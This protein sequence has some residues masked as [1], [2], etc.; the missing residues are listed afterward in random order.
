M[1]REVRDELDATSIKPR[2]GRAL[3][4]LFLLHNVR[5]IERDL[6]DLAIKQIPFAT[7]LAINETLEDVQKNETK[8][9]TRVFDRPTPFTKRAYARKRASKRRLSGSV[10][11]K[12]AQA[13]YLRIQEKGGAR[14]PKRRALVVP[15]GI[16]LN[17]FGNMARGSVAR[18]IADPRVFSGAP[19]GRSKAA[20]GLYR[21]MGK[22]GRGRLRKLAT[23]TPR[24]RYPRRLNFIASARKTAEKRL[25]IH[26]ERSFRR[27]MQTA[28]P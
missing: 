14:L 10:F 11:A 27:A 12:D 23:W 19:N 15:S 7:S 2:K 28:R 20:A 1:V 25:P 3:V 6:S 16:R 17:K 9:L 24:A 13:E 5:D 8:R 22:G 21:R 18:A 4:E 26:M